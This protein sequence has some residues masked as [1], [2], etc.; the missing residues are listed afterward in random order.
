MTDFGLAKFVKNNEMITTF[1]GTPEYLGFF[2][3]NL[4]KIL[5]LFIFIKAPEILNN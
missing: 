3:L 4:L 1:A 5:C 2:I